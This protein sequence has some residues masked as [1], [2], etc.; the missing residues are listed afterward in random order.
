[1]IVRFFIKIKKG[2]SSFMQ[3]L[4]RDEY[5]AVYRIFRHVENLIGPYY[6]FKTRQQIE[7]FASLNRWIMFPV[8]GVDN[9]REGTIYPLPNVFVS[10]EPTIQDDGAGRVNGWL[11]FT[12]HNV[13]AMLSLYDILRKT[14]TQLEFMEIIS[15]LRRRFEVTELSDE[16]SLEIQRK[17]KTDYQASTPKYDTFKAF[18]PSEIIK[19]GNLDLIKQAIKDS[20][21]TLLQK[22]DEYPETG[23]PVLWSVTIFTVVKETAPEYFDADIQQAF[24]S[25][26]QLLSL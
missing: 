5:D 26:F 22:G 19:A 24:S 23:N 8:H 4:S 6:G 3:K 21:K 16:W 2:R 12:Y 11:G 17:T 7:G 25:F 9:L 18:K 20:D 14:S 1:M 10:T 13:E 15:R